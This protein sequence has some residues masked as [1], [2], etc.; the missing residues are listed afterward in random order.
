MRYAILSDIHGNLP[1]LEAVLQDAR[2]Q[3]ADHF[4]FAGDYCISNPMPNECLSLIRS[5][6]N[7]HLIRGNDDQHLERLLGR[8]PASLT[9]GQMRATYWCYRQI[10]PEN[11]TWLFALPHKESLI[12]SG[13][14]IQM[15]HGSDSFI[16]ESEYLDWSTCAFSR[17]YQGVEITPELI[18]RDMQQS[19][20]GD[21]A[22]QEQFGALADGVYIFGHTHIQWSYH[23]PDGKKWLI[24]PGSCGL[25]LDGLGGIPYVLL[26]I[27]QNGTISITPRRLAADP[28]TF[29]EN[30]KKS[31]LYREAPVWS[32][33]II[34]EFH[35]GLEAVS[36]FLQ[37]AAE[38]ADYIDDTRRP[39]SPSTWENAYGLW[40]RRQKNRR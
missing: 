9:D 36:F 19:L 13:V 8:D 23:S 39:F 29:V 32:R 24:N 27:D 5:I 33:L 4:L 11:L 16:E 30:I 1:A 12:D 21:P 14:C 6:P 3:G 22:F 20:D 10:S 18:Q 37:F 31:S 17:R 15:A 7:K 26:D 38:Y 25:S 2:A 35:T 40:S 28:E 34:Q